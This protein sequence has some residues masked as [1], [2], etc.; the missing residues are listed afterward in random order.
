V[1]IGGAM[2]NNLIML[3]VY[4]KLTPSV[5]ADL[6]VDQIKEQAQDRAA[7]LTRNTEAFER[8]LA[9]GKTLDS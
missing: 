6:I 2:I 4:A 3:G 9:L 7:V 5:A 8:G 1:R